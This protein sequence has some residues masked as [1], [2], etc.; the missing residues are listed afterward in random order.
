MEVCKLKDDLKLR[1][2]SRKLN[3]NWFYKPTS[4]YGKFAAI[5]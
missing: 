2:L 5:S 4:K 3:F 1:K